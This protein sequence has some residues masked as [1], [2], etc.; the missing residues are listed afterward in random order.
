MSGP[1]DDR[2]PGDPSW[3]L[4]TVVDEFRGHPGL[5]DVEILRQAPNGTVYQPCVPSPGLVH[6][7]I[8]AIARP[9]TVHQFMFTM[10]LSSPPASGRN[11]K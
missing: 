2:L 10:L 9:Q 8:T 5:S 3:S 6:P 11:A 4:D 7:Y 1:G